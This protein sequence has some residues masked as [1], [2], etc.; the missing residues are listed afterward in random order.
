MS[1]AFNNY[2]HWG[3]RRKNELMN[4]I[5]ERTG[6][7]VYRG[8][9]EGMFIVR[10]FSW[11]DGDTC[12]KLLGIYENELYPAIGEL[13]KE[14]DF[15]LVLNIGCA[16]G[17]YGLGLARMLPNTLS[18]LFDINTTAIEI[19]RENAY[20]N[21]INNVQFNTDCSVE[22]I[23]NYLK[24]YKNPFIIMDIEGHERILLD[25]ELIPELNRS[26][27][28]VESHDCN[29]PGTTDL[30]VNRFG[31]THDVCIISQGAKNPYVKI[32]EDLSDWDK[33]L[34]CCESRPSTMLW[35]ILVPKH[36]KSLAK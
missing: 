26:T 28:I 6:G 25:L 5:Y 9:F 30:I 3:I 22:N 2:M 19:S 24:K 34:L 11:G 21:K 17:Y 36:L 23:R 10:K 31:E 8:P 20:L 35:V 16:E 18:V 13:T 12:G 1:E 29:I 14:N 32:I 27:V 4:L 15:D 33:M 7:K